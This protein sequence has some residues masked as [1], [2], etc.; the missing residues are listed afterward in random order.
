MFAI[1]LCMN[2][3]HILY[4]ASEWVPDC[5]RNYVN[6]IGFV[7]SLDCINFPPVTSVKCSINSAFLTHFSGIL[8]N[9]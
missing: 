3:L 7:L 9:F 8:A 5:V 1:H 4:H 2:T 6:S